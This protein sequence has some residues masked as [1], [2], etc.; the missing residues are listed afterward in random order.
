MHNKWCNI[1]AVIG[2]W[3]TIALKRAS[4]SLMRW[5]MWRLYFGKFLNAIGFPASVNKCDYRSNALGVTVKVEHRDLFTVITVN[6]LD[7]YFKRISGEIDGVGISQASYCTTGGTL[8][9]ADL[10]AIPFASL[11]LP[12][13][14][15]TPGSDG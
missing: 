7:V 13:K 11:P 6:G 3:V 8:G 10:G 4:N 12:Q 2:K 15:N 5:V 9:L 1:L 14:Q